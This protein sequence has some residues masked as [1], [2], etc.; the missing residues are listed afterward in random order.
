MAAS[1]RSRLA[2]AVL[3]ACA[4]GAGAQERAQLPIELRAQSQD[5][6]Y[7]NGILKFD[8]ITITQGEIRITAERAVANGLD[9]EESKW[10]FTGTVRI[11]MPES[12]LASDSAQVRFSKGEVAS[13]AI[14]GA[15]ATFEQQRKDEH[16]QGRANRIDYDLKRGTVILEGDAWLS[17]SG[18][19]ITGS[20]LVYSMTNQRVI[21]DTPVTITIQPG[22][23][24]KVAPK[25]KPEP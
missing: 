9:F 6:D 19:E 2:A 1:S 3:A 25:P 12:T 7:R 22:E 10:Q 15:P 4:L 17:D 14:T 21:S 18:K 20:K 11:S 8:G 16:A 24:P 13:A 23:A 5:F